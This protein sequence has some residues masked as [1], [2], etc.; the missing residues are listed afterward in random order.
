[1]SKDNYSTFSASDSDSGPYYCA[2]HP[3]VETYLRCA[4]CEKPI[5]PKC[6]VSTPVGFRCFDCAQLTVL[7]TYAISTDYYVKAGVAG[8]LAASAAGALMGI[9]PGFEFWAALLMGVVVPEAVTR[10]A[11]LKR[12]PGL[13]AV[14]MGAIVFGFVVSRVVLHFFP[15]LIPMDGINLPYLFSPIR[16]LRGDPF[17]LSQFTIIWLALALFLANR[18]LR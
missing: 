12:G 1:M 16:S 17:Y 2:K 10:A 11:N 4:K 3:T 13:Q 6:R 14:A 15:L 18:R 5:C 8:L 9:F 7:P